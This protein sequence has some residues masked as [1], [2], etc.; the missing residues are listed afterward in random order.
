[1][2]ARDELEKL[3]VSSSA[4]MVTPSARRGNIGAAADGTDT[5]D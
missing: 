2:K 3:K 5:P 4:N 1:M